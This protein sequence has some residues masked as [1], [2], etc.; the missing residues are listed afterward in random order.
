M[1][2]EG[3][4]V[5]S[6][7]RASLCDLVHRIQTSSGRSPPPQ[8]EVASPGG[9]RG[10]ELKDPGRE[11]L[12]WKSREQVHLSILGAI[13][14]SFFVGRGLDCVEKILRCVDFLGGGEGG[15]ESVLYS[16][17]PQMPSHLMLFI[18]VSWGELLMIVEGSSSMSGGEMCK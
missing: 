18:H 11:G 14:L 16:L 1:A 5:H 17:Y 15:Y 12:E 9:V 7:S 2:D 4:R 13:V 3:W 10:L 8:L 6:I